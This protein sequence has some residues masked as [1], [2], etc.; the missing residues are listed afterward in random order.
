MWVHKAASYP[1]WLDQSNRRMVLFNKPEKVPF[2]A[3]ERHRRWQSPRAY[4]DYEH[5]KKSD[6]GNFKQILEN[7]LNEPEMVYFCKYFTR[8]L[9]CCIK[10]H[11]E[12]VMWLVGEPNSGRT[13][14]FTSISCPIPA[15]YIAM[16]SKQK[17]FKKSL[18]DENTP[19]I[20]LDE[21]HANVMDPD[22]W[23]ILTQGVLTT[24]DH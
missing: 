22:D 21:T 2:W 19:R 4:V 13:S 14:L 6:P 3:C 11:K 1:V 12:K 23:K 9:N 16:I 24:H 7:S 17:A 8:L 20:F 15:R 5:T 10:Q 18:L